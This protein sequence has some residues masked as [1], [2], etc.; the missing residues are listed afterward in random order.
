M[1]ALLPIV[2]TMAMELSDF[3]CNPRSYRRRLQARRPP[4][5]FLGSR[6]V[7]E[8]IR[9]AKQDLARTLRMTRERLRHRAPESSDEAVLFQSDDQLR[10]SSRMRDRVGI[11]R[12]DRVHAEN[13]RGDPLWAEQ[14]GCDG[15]CLEH[16]AGRDDADI[17]PFTQLQRFPDDKIRRGGMHRPLTCFPQ[18]QIIRTGT[19]GDGAHGASDFHRITRANDGHIRDGPQHGDV[20]QRVMRRAQV[21]V[22]SLIHI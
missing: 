8:A 5:K 13:A 12:L 10:L 18:A 17:L 19:I 1:S 7:G 11:E 16:R 14:I 20:F 21:P 6:G 22:L 3:F 15:G 2:F 9:R 4:E